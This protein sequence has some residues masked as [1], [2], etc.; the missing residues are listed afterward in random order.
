M[1]YYSLVRYIGDGSNRTFSVPF[2]YLKATDVK[3]YVDGVDTTFSWLTTS[4]LQVTTAPPVSSVVVVKRSTDKA[5]KLVDYNNGSIL[6]EVALDTQ[7]DQLMYIAQENADV[8]TDSIVVDDSGSIDML[9]RKITN[10]GI[11]VQDS[12]VVNL[13]YIIGSLASAVAGATAAAELAQANAE[14][15]EV[16]AE[17]AEA[18]AETAQG[19]AEDARDATLAAIAT[20][21]VVTDGDK[22]DIT[23]SGSGAT[24]T[25]DNNVVTPAK[26][27]RTGTAGQVLTS[28]GT[29]ADPSYQDATAGGVQIQPI[30]AA[31][32]SNAL[33]I[34]ASALTLD[35]RSATLGSGAIT[36]VTGTPANLVIPSGATLGT[37]SAQQ[38][39]LIVIALNN[40][41]TIELAA[42]NIAGGNN[43]DETTLIS[44]TAVST[45]ADSANVVY[46]TTARTNLPFRVIGLI[47]STQATAGTWATAPS[48]IQG[49][50]GQALTSMSSL[51]YGQT[52][53][54]VVGSRSSGAT[55]YN[56]TGKPIQI[57]VANSSAGVAVVVNGVTIAT[58]MTGIFSSP[59]FVVPPNASYVVT[60]GGFTVWVELR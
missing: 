16:N 41:G 59:S 2:Q 53:Q 14:L 3:V 11:P 24:W 33:T 42:V 29:G 7:T 35:F 48:L 57:Y 32:G 49:A 34:S 39:R 4:S 1:S 55:Y 8:A 17:T 10:V 26:M 58:S 15:A 18:N 60:S 28:G 27:S 52:W 6:D 13:G 40:A 45:A 51:G 21:G 23:V 54:S 12:D 50:G 25:L 19:L 47:Q 22:G 20:A 43:L 44:T 37:I 30:S 31:V 46:S 9:G 5:T 56:T 38:S 36:S